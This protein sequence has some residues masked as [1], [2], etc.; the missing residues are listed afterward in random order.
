M[1]FNF[2]VDPTKRPTAMDWQK[3]KESIT[4]PTIYELDGNDLKLCFPVLPKKGSGTKLDIKR[5]N[6]FDTRGK[7]IM[8]LTLKRE[9]K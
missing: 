7:P 4:L 5:P 3:D 6:S 8:F 9:K 1:S 2:T